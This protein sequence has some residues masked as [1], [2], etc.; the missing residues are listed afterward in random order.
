[1]FIPM[2]QV[3]ASDNATGLEVLT[4]IVKNMTGFI[5]CMNSLDAE[6]GHHP[7]EQQQSSIVYGCLN[8]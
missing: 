8:K 2:T 1:M 3:L 5:G 6:Y 7:T 4:N